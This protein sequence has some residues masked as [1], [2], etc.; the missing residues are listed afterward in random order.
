MEII[1]FYD[2]I[3]LKLFQLDIQGICIDIIIP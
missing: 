2:V 3:Q 1:R